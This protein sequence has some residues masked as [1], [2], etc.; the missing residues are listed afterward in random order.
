MVG[1]QEESGR[2]WTMR[3]LEYRSMKSTEALTVEKA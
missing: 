1:M 3:E 2:S